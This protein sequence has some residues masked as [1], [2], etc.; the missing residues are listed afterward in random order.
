MVGDLIEIA[1]NQRERLVWT[2]PLQLE[3]FRDRGSRARIDRESIKR[4]CWKSNDASV[5]ERGDRGQ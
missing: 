4:L 2:T 1:G 3:Y 5:T